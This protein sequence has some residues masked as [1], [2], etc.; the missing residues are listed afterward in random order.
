MTIMT[1]FLD[2]TFG[3]IESDSSEAQ[4]SVWTPPGRP[5]LV[6]AAARPGGLLFFCRGVEDT[7]D[8]FEKI[9]SP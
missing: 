1:G 7:M 8:A 9:N 6:G 4:R 3:F 5:V 2:R